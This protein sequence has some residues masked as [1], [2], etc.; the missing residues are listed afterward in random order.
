[1]EAQRNKLTYEKMIEILKCLKYLRKK[2]LLLEFEINNYQPLVTGED[3]ID[4]MNF[5]RNLTDCERTD[6][7]Y[8]TAQIA[9]L[10]GKETDAI[11]IQ[12]KEELEIELKQL[13]LE[14]ARIEFYLSL[15]EEKYGKVL[16]MLYIE[17]CTIAKVAE[18]LDVSDTTVKNLR[19][20]GVNML[21]DMYDSV[22]K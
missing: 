20:S 13:Q 22:S 4:H 2:I 18:Y 16:K 6:P 14:M 15:L 8:N 1:M 10:Y 3:I 11:N 5:N 21:I 17:G 19:K 7:V 12:H 9:L